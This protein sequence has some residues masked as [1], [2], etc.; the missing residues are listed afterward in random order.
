M[1]VTSHHPAHEPVDDVDTGRVQIGFVDT[2]R[3]FDH[4]AVSR[5]NA[6]FFETF[7]GML[8]HS[9]RPHKRNAF[10]DMDSD[11]VLE[12]GAGTGANLHLLAPGTRL[13][14]VEPSRRMH[15]RL[16]RRARDVGVEL[17]IL[18]TVAEAIPL[19]DA[20]VDDVVCSLVLCTV[21][22]PD[23]AL[24]EVRRVL[25]PGGRFR[26]VEHVAAPRGVRAAVQR[27]I[28]GPWGWL[29]EGCDPHRDTPDILERA[30]FS[31]L[32]IERRRLRHSPFWPVNTA[33]W[34]VATR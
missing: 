19:P 27:A 33:V 26:F 22:D 17:T 7:D 24:A 15:R 13:Y 3:S 6:W 16:A 5:F 31:D 32:R 4:G 25:R 14:A 11:V 29:F 34:G 20:S 30:G 2:D 1:T 23:A 28:R 21:S 18:P 12:L 9:L 10:A 8:N